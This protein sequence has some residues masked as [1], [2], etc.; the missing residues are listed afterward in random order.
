MSPG[1]A[2]RCVTC[3]SPASYRYCSSTCFIVYAKKHGKPDCAVC[4]FDPKTER[5]GSIRTSRICSWCAADPANGEWKDVSRKERK[6]FE[7]D[8]FAAGEDAVAVSVPTKFSSAKALKAMKLIAAGASHEEAATASGLKPGY[9]KH[10][11]SHWNKESSN[12][13]KSLNKENKK[14]A[15]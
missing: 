6:G 2:T 11:S 3:K 13:L 7:M 8:D 1:H 15:K 5:V 14:Q 10:I 4:C 9:I 12:L